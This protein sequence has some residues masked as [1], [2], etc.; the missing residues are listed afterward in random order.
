MRVRYVIFAVLSLGACGRMAGSVQPQRAD[1]DVSAIEA[2]ECTENGQTYPDGSTWLCSDGCNT[3]SCDKGKLVAALRGCPPQTSDSGVR[4]GTQ[5]TQ[6]ASCLPGSF[7]HFVWPGDAG[8]CVTM[9]DC[10]AD[11]HLQ[12]ITDCSAPDY[13]SP[14]W[15]CEEGAEC[16]WAGCGG[17]VPAD[18]EGCR[19][20]CVCDDSSAHYRCTQNCPNICG[21]P[22]AP[23]CSICA[24]GD[25][26]CQHY[27]LVDGTCQIALCGVIIRGL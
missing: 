27:A 7:R 16:E 12:C 20:G 4:Y 11:L 8:A 21:I 15:T 10:Q 14:K 22:E 23:S 18:P 3:C 19:T 24:N 2:V 1:A 9:C 13:W 25:V 6:G 5:W 17:P 26:E